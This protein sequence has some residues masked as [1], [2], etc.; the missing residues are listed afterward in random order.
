[1]GPEEKGW[2]SQT[3]ESSTMRQNL[4]PWEQTGSL[5][6]KMKRE[7]GKGQKNLGE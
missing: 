6:E 5:A 7:K 2:T 3:L 4:K 1:M